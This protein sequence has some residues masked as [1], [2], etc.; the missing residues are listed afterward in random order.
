MAKKSVEKIANLFGYGNPDDSAVAETLDQLKSSALRI[1]EEP[2]FQKI[3]K[4]LV[5]V[6]NSE[7]SKC[8]TC[9]PGHKYGDLEFSK[10]LVYG[11]MLFA[12]QLKSIATMG[13][14]RDDE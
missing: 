5:G 12:N 3:H 2:A 8:F 6:H 4:L 9:E 1:V 10:G 7:V 14:H 11:V 13:E